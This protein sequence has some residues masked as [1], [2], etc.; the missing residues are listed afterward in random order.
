MKKI[1]KGQEPTFL[2][3][4]QLAHATAP[5][6]QY[7][8]NADRRNQVQEQIR[9]DQG[10][11]CAYCEIDFR[12]ADAFSSADFRIEHFHPKSDNGG[13]HNWGLDWQ[14][15]LGCCDGGSQRDVVDSEKRF[16]SP[17][18]S[19]DVPKDNENF[20]EVILNPLLLPASPNLFTYS[21]TTG[22]MEVHIDNCLRAGVDVEKAQNTIDN[23]RLNAKRL[24]DL[25]RPI[26]VHLNR[27][28]NRLV[29]QG[30]SAVDARRRLAR[31]ILRRNR[32][33]NWP[34]FFSAIRAYLGKQ[35]E[36]QLERIGY[37]G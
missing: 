34:A 9:E 31:A 6:E 24:T 3:E 21:R 1:I 4:Y 2:R 22:R 23:L 33:G 10:G 29:S 35:A 13:E 26:L 19:C 11:L 17:D 15:L 37:G 27:Q 16:T 20:D 32:A 28:Y 30:F 25:R 5:W 14:N 8:K 36:E 12:R 7:R 18:Y